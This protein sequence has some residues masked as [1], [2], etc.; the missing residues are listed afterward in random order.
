MVR[1]TSSVLS[2]FFFFAA[3]GFFFFGIGDFF[4]LL[5][6]VFIIG[7]SHFRFVL[8]IFCCQWYG[9]G[10]PPVAFGFL[11]PTIMLLFISVQFLTVC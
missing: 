1:V 8:P 6:A 9:A 2:F 10:G 11:M 3:S 5:L 4:F 7:F